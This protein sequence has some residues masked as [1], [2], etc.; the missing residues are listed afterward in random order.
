MAT[1]PLPP[2][3]GALKFGWLAMLNISA[4]NWRRKRLLD[5][6][7]LEE[8]QVEP[9][10]ARTFHLRD[11]TQ[12]GGSCQRNAAGRCVRFGVKVASRAQG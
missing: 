10:E 7:V 8:G 12:G 2:K 6:E 11:S 5:R 4:R 1:T 9:V 3:P